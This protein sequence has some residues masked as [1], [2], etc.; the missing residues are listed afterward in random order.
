MMETAAVPTKSDKGRL[1]LGLITSPPV[2][3][4]LFHASDENNGPTNA[5][6][7]NVSV[8]ISQLAP[9]QNPC[10]GVDGTGWL[11]AHQTP[12][13]ITPMRAATLR[14]VKTFWTPAPVRNP[15]MFSTLRKNNTRIA[16]S[17]CDETVSAMGWPK[18]GRVPKLSRMVL[19]ETHGL[20]HQKEG[21]SVEK[22]PKWA[23]CFAKVNILPAG[24]R[25]HPCQLTVTNSGNDGHHPTD[26]PGEKEQAGR[27][28]LTADV[29]SDNKDARTNHRSHHQGGGVKQAEALHEIGRL[30]VRRGI[31]FC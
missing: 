4:T 23:K 2:K 3:V 28:N 20:N 13:T 22:T 30:R 17:C 29:G 18:P 16:T 15:K 25:H 31:G 24:P 21:P 12:S 11:N 27:L 6:E 5:T 1:R 19:A 10:V 26:D 8:A 7:T 14:T 9:C